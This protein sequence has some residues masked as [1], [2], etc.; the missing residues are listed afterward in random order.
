MEARHRRLIRLTTYQSRTHKSSL[1]IKGP[2]T[3]V[4]NEYY[5]Q[6]TTRK[7]EARCSEIEKKM[8]EVEEILEGL[9]AGVKNARKTYTSLEA[10]ICRQLI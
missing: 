7:I 5:V 2:T 1:Y 4:L 6:Q 3:F 8:R 10:E 9:V